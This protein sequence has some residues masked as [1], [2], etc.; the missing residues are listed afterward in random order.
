M[1]ILEGDKKPGKRWCS[2]KGD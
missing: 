2:F 1:K